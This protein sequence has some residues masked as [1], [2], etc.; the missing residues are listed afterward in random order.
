[1]NKTLTL[2][3]QMG[4]KTNRTTFIRGNRSGHHNAHYRRKDMQFDSMN[5]IKTSKKRGQSQVI[6]SCSTCGTHHVTLV[7]N[8]DIRSGT[9]QWSKSLWRP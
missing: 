4:D 3:K 2:T 9:Y 8:P 7:S 5:N 6:S 1:M